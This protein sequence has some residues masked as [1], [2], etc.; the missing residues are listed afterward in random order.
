[1]PEWRG[2]ARVLVVL[3]IAAAYSDVG[4]ALE[5][6]PVVPPTFSNALAA[7]MR[8]YYVQRSG[9]GPA[10]VSWRGDCYMD[11]GSDVG[12]DLKGVYLPSQPIPVP[13]RRPI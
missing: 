11:D 13:Y 3:L 12:M 6:L 9:E 7:S 1:M 2:V 10:E 8:F 5:P 4:T